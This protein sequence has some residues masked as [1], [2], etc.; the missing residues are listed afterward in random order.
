MYIPKHFEGE[1]AQGR[2][3]MQAHSWARLTTADEAGVPV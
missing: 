3:I 2:E 1:E